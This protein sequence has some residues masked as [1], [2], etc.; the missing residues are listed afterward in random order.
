[1]KLMV[2]L[3]MLVATLISAV[4]LAPAQQS[5][6]SRPQDPAAMR[7]ASAS[8]FKATENIEFRTA[9]IISEGVRLNAELF[10]LKSLAGKPLPT[11]I[12]AHGWGGTAAIFRWD[13]LA[14][15]NA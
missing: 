13:A 4:N 11:I 2:K 6:P 3:A 5:N 10:S 1:M 14:L 8:G 15:A 7:Q 9:S 12:M